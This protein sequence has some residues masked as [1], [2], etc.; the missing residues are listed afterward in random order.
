M[1][2]PIYNSTS[3][4]KYGGTFILLLLLLLNI[5]IYF[6]FILL[7]QFR[8]IF[9]YVSAYGGDL[10]WKER[11]YVTISGFPKATVQVCY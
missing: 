2:L 10:N 8:L 4:K 7:F 11:T 5:F 9:S 1:T 6:Y 3:L